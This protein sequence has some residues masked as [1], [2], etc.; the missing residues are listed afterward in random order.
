MR[1]NRPDFRYVLHAE[2]DKNGHYEIMT[3][4][5]GRPIPDFLVHVP[6]EMGEI[7]NLVVIEVKIATCNIKEVKEDISKIK[8]FINKINYKYDIFLR[9]GE[10]LH[11]NLIP[12][13]EKIVLLHHKKPKTKPEII[14]GHK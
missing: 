2:F 11:A 10:P 3:L 13:N 4:L 7:D 1:K 9:F 6:G 8:K 12:P 14:G 5:N